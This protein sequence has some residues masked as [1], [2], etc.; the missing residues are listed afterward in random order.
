MPDVGG[1]APIEDFNELSG[2]VRRGA[3]T[4]ALV[5]SII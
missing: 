5:N 4:L 2:I 1:K 3:E